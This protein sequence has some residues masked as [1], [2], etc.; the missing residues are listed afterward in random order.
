[1]SRNTTAVVL[2]APAVVPS[3]PSRG[4]VWPSAT[5][6]LSSTSIRTRSPNAL[7]KAVVTTIERFHKRH[8]YTEVKLCVGAK[9]AYRA[10]TQPWDE[11]Q[12]GRVWPESVVTF[13]GTTIKTRSVEALKVELDKTLERFQKKHAATVGTWKLD[14]QYSK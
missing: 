9:P 10:V 8:A 7:E 5:V 6:R 2:E 11:P 13:S 14:I 3:K 4:R 12:R 1:M